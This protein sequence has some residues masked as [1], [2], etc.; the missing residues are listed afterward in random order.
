LGRSIGVALLR[1]DATSTSTMLDVDADGHPLRAR[2][3]ATPFGV[4]N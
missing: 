1:A 3:T 4:V 2:V